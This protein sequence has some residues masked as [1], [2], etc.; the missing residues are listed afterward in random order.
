MVYIIH[1]AAPILAAAAT[2]WVFGLAWYALPFDSGR[3][4]SAGVLTIDALAKGWIAAILAGALILAPV[5]ADIWT[6]A[7]GSAFIIWIGFVLPAIAAS[8][9][10][11]ALSWRSMVADAA[12]WLIAMLLMAAIMR[13]IGVEPPDVTP[14]QAEDVARAR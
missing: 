11:R 4:R 6:V 2:A 1:N 12:H 9:T 8:Y 14:T 7:L 3:T 5:E 13:V 10:R